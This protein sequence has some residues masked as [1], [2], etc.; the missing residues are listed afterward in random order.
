M[1]VRFHHGVP[2]MESNAGALV[3]RL[4]LKTRFS[5]M[6]WGSTPLLSAKFW[7]M[8]CKVRQEF[9]KLSFRNGLTGSIPVSSAKL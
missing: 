2:V 7:K 4:A 8:C 1:V 6:G 3:R 9:A 5:E